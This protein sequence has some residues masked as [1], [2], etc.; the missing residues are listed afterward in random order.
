MASGGEGDGGSGIGVFLSAVSTEFAAARK[1]IRGDL[2]AKN[3]EVREQTEFV[4]GDDKTTLERLHTYIDGCS[5]VLCIIGRRA[6]AMPPLKAALPYLTE[7][8]EILPEDFMPSY[9]QWELIFAH[10]KQKRLLIFH[11]SDTYVPDETTGVEGDDADL[12]ADFVNWIFE[13]LGLNRGNFSTNDELARL[14]LRE[15][16][17]T[18]AANGLKVSASMTNNGLRGTEEA[19]RLQLR[20]AGDRLRPSLSTDR[21]AMR[22]RERDRSRVEKL[23]TRAGEQFVEVIGPDGVGKKKL[24]A[25]FE[26]D[27]SI[28]TTDPA[29]LD[30]VE[31]LVQS[32]WESLVNP[33]M[34]AVVPGQRD[35][36]LAALEAV[37]FAADVDS[38]EQLQILFAAMPRARFFI[39]ARAPIS[40][41]GRRLELAPLGPG[42]EQTMLEIFADRY[43]DDIPEELEPAIIDICSSVGG[44]PAF[45]VQQALA[46]EKATSLQEWV[47]ERQ[48][49]LTT[50]DLPPDMVPGG[51]AVDP[52]TVARAVGE[53][54]PRDV[55][56]GAT[57][58]E[59][60]DAAEE[61]CEVVRGS[62]RYRANGALDPA[63][64][65]DAILSDVLDHAVTWASVAGSREI[66]DSRP[67]VVRMVRWGVDEQRWAAVLELGRRCEP[68]MALGGRH[69]AWQ[70]VLDG[71]L[72][73]A[74]SLEDGA[75]EGWALHELG[76]RALIRD[77]M[78]EARAQLAAAYRT[79]R[80]HDPDAAALSRHNLRLVPGAVLTL[81][82]ILVA[83][84]V[85]LGWVAAVRTTDGLYDQP[86]AEI[87][88]EVGRYR[89]LRGDVPLRFTIENVGS[90]WLEVGPFL[91]PAG[92]E[93]APH[94]CTERLGPGEQCVLPIAYVGTEREGGG[95]LE[96][97]VGLATIGLTSDRDVL[98]DRA[99]LL[100]AEGTG[101][102]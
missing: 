7:Y 11:A 71:S 88:P 96:P 1:L 42:D 41:Q 28:V 62:P 57:S 24:L 56:I 17:A 23:L 15:D 4:Q 50:G 22:G 52:A 76:S 59:S 35:R 90:G 60:T 80:T 54:V 38:I 55:V 68:A 44:N 64:D 20:A 26:D 98:G 86:V 6:G 75:A 18:P 91:T 40:D 79:R 99:I 49:P 5:T 70:E 81:V 85:G 65:G 63:I 95:T 66:L 21:Y 46:A 12:Q 39:T 29:D 16:W 36:A 102:S 47:A 2:A 32:A 87:T 82:G 33:P 14:V 97:T 30:R 100:V 84:V 93:T 8:A 58:L 37:V 31:D 10:Q 74:R 72:V 13:D 83:L 51:A 9:T 43:L 92:F 34:G 69:G 3:W 19:P 61:R 45:I 101:E 25:Q 78:P 77:D 53:S 48:Q 27:E 89:R 67:F 73:A 94:T